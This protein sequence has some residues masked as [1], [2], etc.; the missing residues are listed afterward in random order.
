MHILPA[1]GSATRMG[2]IPKFLLPIGS[3]GKPLIRLHLEMAQKAQLET[4]VM[5]NPQLFDYGNELI[6]S[7]KLPGVSVFKVLSP[8]M[9]KT[10]KV[11]LELS[12]SK[13][14]V[15]SIS[16]PDTFFDALISD[17]N[18][19]LPTIRKNAPSLAVWKI[20]EDQ[21]GKLGQVETSKDLVTVLSL[22]DKNPT[23]PFDY[24]WGMMAIPSSQLLNFDELDS[25]PGISLAKELKNG[26]K[27]SCTPTTGDYLDCGT[28]AEY[29]LAVSKNLKFL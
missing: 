1:A 15:I 7:W 29:Y 25:H 20:R 19:L 13:D 14:E 24:S 27:V 10:A 21:R 22:V 23:C 17:D 4:V 26:L 9:T 12:G 11:A 3:S 16:M 5:L 2:G 8:T 6:H 18:Y 28:P